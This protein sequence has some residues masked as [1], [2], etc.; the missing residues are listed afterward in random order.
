[1]RLS[2]RRNGIADSTFAVQIR[3]TNAQAP[4]ATVLG[5]VTVNESSLGTSYAYHDFTFTG[6]SGLSPIAPIAIVLQPIS[7]TN[8]AEWQFTGSGGSINA[9]DAMFQ[10]TNAG[11]TWTRLN[12]QEPLFRVTGT[13]SASAPIT[14]PMD[15]VRV[16]R[17]TAE[18]LRGVRAA[19]EAEARGFGSAT[20]S[21]IAEEVETR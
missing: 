11:S 1:V 19:F 14:E 2:L 7:G 20:A 18:A 6:V 16:V 21:V 8:A 13:P 10:S 4:T 3:T 5:S 9:A 12:G 17:V 15:V